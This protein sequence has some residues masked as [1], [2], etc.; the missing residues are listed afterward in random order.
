MMAQIRGSRF[1]DDIDGTNSDDV[2]EGLEGH[3][4]IWGYG[5]NDLLIGGSGDD[6]LDGGSGADRMEGGTG[7]DLFVVDSTGDLVVE[8]AGEGIDV[9]LSRLNTY[10]LGANVEDLVAL[11]AA[12]FHGIGNAL[13][14]YIYGYDGDDI[15]DGAGGSDVLI[16][17]RG[18]DTY[19]VDQAGDQVIEYSG[20]GYDLV[21]TSLAAL[22]LA[23]N[24]EELIFD[25]TGAFTGTGNARDNYIEGAAGN[26][27][28]DGLDG[29]DILNGAAGADRMTGGGGD[30][31]FIVDNAGD[32]AI[33]TSATGGID[34]VESSVNFVLGANV[35]D[36]VL[37]G[38][39]A[40]NGTGNALANI[41]TGNSA[42]NILNGG[43]GADLMRGGGGNDTYVVDNA[44]DTVVESSAAGGID[45]VN[46]SVSFVLGA[47]VENLFLTGT[48]A[49][50][51]IGNLLANKIV[52]NGSA[53]TLSGLGGNDSV[54]GG[55]GNDR[56]FGGSGNDRLDGGAGADDFFFDTAL[57]ASTNVDSI[58]AFS[59]PED[60]IR[61]SRS[62][63]TA[64]GASGPLDPDAFH[65]GSAALDAEDRIVYSQASGRL[66]YDPDGSGAAAQILFATVAAGTPLTSADFIAY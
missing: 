3:D 50:N 12:D 11:S 39:A 7:D 29:N 30:D 54:T 66:F 33:E 28:L 17:E 18:D 31:I 19:F 55:G 14:N 34:T 51:G 52:G 42:A 64:I 46:S 61:L 24:V 20:E 26:D 16:G 47:N 8:L 40:V 57:S 9:V 60:S 1:S 43:T 2:I 36:L 63:F 5:G 62:V 25:G 53:N 22:T 41:L 45:R 15:L 10:T 56:L 4:R 35:E 59:V 65:Q 32:R 23:A 27:L 58:L 38:T 6:D 13:D 37:T 21:F 49:V 48:A 44:G